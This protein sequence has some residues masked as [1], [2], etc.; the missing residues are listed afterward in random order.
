M[1]NLSRIKE[2]R[3]NNIYP[4]INRPPLAFPS[5]PMNRNTGTH[6][7]SYF[8]TCFAILRPQQSR[9]CPIICIY[10]RIR[11]EYRRPLCLTANYL[12]L[13][14]SRTSPSVLVYQAS[15]LCNY[16]DLLKL[17]T[18]S[19]LQ[20]NKKILLP[21]TIILT[22]LNIIIYRNMQI[23]ECSIYMSIPTI[24]SKNS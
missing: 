3:Q 8:H 9:I 10:K 21:P 16:E 1:L 20:N 14:W 22:T 2:W 11:Q 18:C 4:P 15:F 7:M 5:Q 24:S 17:Y 19:T 6:S 13:F 12:S 23:A